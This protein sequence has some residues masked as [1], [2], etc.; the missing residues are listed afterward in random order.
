[1]LTELKWPTVILK[2]GILI[3]SSGISGYDVIESIFLKRPRREADHSLSSVD[4]VK[5]AWIYTS[6]PSY[7]FKTWC[8][9]CLY[10][11]VLS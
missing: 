11:V 2:G 6:T 3:C 9:S 4:E 8:F 5:N 1:M 7:V 10:G